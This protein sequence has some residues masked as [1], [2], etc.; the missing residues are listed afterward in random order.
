MDGNVQCMLLLVSV[1][2][3]NSQFF[4]GSN[5]LGTRTSRPVSFRRA[6][7]AILLLT[8]DAHT[9]ACRRFPIKSIGIS[10]K[11]NK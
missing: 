10:E 6:C 3:V 9:M 7:A 11:P 8:L 1:T 4:G 5:N 2:V